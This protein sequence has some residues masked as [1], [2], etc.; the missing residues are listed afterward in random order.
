MSS[1]D[2]I[3]SKTDSY[4]Y[5]H[6]YSELEGEI[7]HPR[8]KTNVC[9]VVLLTCQDLKLNQQKTIEKCLYYMFRV[10]LIPVLCLFHFKCV[11]SEWFFLRLLQ[12]NN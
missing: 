4:W 11:E 1:Q 9:Q 3:S 6:L 10:F 8:G 7:P 12:N 2:L 5:I